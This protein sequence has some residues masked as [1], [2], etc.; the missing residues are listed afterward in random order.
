MTN[1][2][3]HDENRIDS[4]QSIERP[5]DVAGLVLLHKLSSHHKSAVLESDICGCFYCESLFPAAEVSDWTIEPSFGEVT[6]LCPRC[7]IDAVL[8]SSTVEKA[9]YEL[10]RTVLSQMKDYWFKPV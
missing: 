2:F 10:S 4:P 9:G 7:E 5:M 1:N 8:P 3:T 6:A